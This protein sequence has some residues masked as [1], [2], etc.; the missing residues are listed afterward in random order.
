LCDVGE[1]LLPHFPHH[2]SL[3]KPTAQISDSVWVA[4]K[5]RLEGQS[6]QQPVTPDQV[7]LTKCK[8]SG[9]AWTSIKL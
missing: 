9:V 2:T 3:T 5:Q 7:F 1:N 6:S 8:D 4:E